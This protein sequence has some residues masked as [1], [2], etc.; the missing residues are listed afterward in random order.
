MILI[1]VLAIIFG[2]FMMYVARIHWV[3][4]HISMTEFSM[5]LSLWFVF[6]FIAVFPETVGDFAQTLHIGRILDLLVICALMLLVYLTFINRITY[7]RLEK[8]LEK[9]VR[10]NAI[11]EKK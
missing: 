5:W 3:K 4:K 1:Q 8:K 10:K 11:D 9:L 7:K 2:L 6:I